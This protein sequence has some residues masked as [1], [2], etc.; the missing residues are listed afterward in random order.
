MR[1]TFSETQHN[2]TIYKWA[3]DD[4]MERKKK[5]DEK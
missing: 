3:L 2:F 4:Y 5:R 1:D